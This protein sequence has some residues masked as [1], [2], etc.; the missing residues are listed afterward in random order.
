[1][2]RSV[3]ILVLFS[4]VA[5]LPFSAA[6]TGT[7]IPPATTT[8]TPV[9]P[10]PTLTPSPSPAPTATSK[11]LIPNFQHIVIIM[12]ENKE[13]GTVIGNPLMPN[14]NRLAREYTLL[15]Q[16]YAIR[17]PSLPNYIALIG[18]DTFGI[19]TNC[20]DCFI[21]APSLPDLIEDSSRTW[22]TYQE[23][24]PEP[25]FLGDTHLYVQ[26]HNPFIYF[27][28]IRLDRARCERSIVRLTELQTDIEAGSLPN[29]I[30]ITPNLCNDA[31]DC[32]LDVAD[33]WLTELLGRLVPALDAIS[34]SYLI[35]MLFEEGQGN[36][37]CCGL[38]LE[39]GGRVPVVFY[40][41]LVK[42]GFEDPT[43][44]THYSLLKTISTAWGLPLLGH[45][46]EE[47]H[48]LIVEPWK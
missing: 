11:P 45:A 43:P 32:P 19:E 37:S 42:N 44:Y 14:Y 18:G 31:H 15:T 6:L 46:A 17:H 5:C 10:S 24:M 34:E 16:Y 36:H 9:P 26:K 22:K 4:L 12:F 3:C 39:A 30:F 40:S 27:D 8:A 1:M 38:P 25:C 2:N 47:N 48:V 7:P 13:F 41:P 23:D 28:P 20:S 35:V 21:D 29:F 33:A